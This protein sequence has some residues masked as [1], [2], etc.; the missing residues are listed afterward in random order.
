MRVPSHSSSV[1]PA[2]SY[3]R[4]LVD[5]A[6]P[7]PARAWGSGRAWGGGGML[8]AG[9]LPLALLSL[10]EGAPGSAPALPLA[11]GAAGAARTG[12]LA[13]CGPS[14]FGALLFASSILFP[15]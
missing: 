9:P 11:S 12:A 1:P 15:S 3:P 4:A 2:P 7:G 14:V 5:W 6:G 10:A 8:P 13:F